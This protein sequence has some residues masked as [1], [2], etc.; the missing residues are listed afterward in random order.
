MLSEEH[1]SYHYRPRLAPALVAK[2]KARAALA[3]LARGRKGKRYERSLEN[4]IAAL[5]EKFNPPK[6][7]DLWPASEAVTSMDK[8]MRRFCLAMGVSK[9]EL[10]SERRT[11][12]LAVCRQ[13]IYYWA[14]RRTALSMPQIGRKIGDRDHTT[15]LYGI[16]AYIKKRAAQGRTLRP[17]RR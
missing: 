4:R 2:Q 9:R 8:I 7:V 6:P 13:A 10:L 17:V 15:I 16:D 1:P 5:E 14:Y 11:N 3:E 12:R